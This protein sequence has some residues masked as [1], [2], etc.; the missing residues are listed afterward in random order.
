VIEPERLLASALGELTGDAEATVEE[1]VLACG[2]CAERYAA[3]V[4]M[5]PAVADLIRTARVALPITKTLLD[6]FEAAGL[7]TRRYVLAPGSTVPCTV[8]AEDIYSVVRFEAD[9]RGA[10]QVD[11]IRGNVRQVDVP[12]DPDAGVVYTATPASALRT[13]PTMKLQFRLVAID[14]HGERALA[15]YTLDHTAFAP[16]ER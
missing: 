13:L 9:F 7:V 4:R 6:R 16:S 2:P 3:F 8:G 15:D 14:A 12:F 1:H 5:G 10:S 11:L